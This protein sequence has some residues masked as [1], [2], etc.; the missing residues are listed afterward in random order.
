MSEKTTAEEIQAKL[1]QTFD[2]IE[3]KFAALEERSKDALD[4]S[5][6]QKNELEKL[7]QETKELGARLLDL[8]SAGGPDSGKPE[9]KSIGHEFANS[10][11]LRTL[12]EGGTKSIGMEFKNTLTNATRNGAQ[13]LVSPDHI[14]D[15]Q[16]Q[17]NRRLFLFDLMLK[18]A[19]SSNV[20]SWPRETVVNRAGPQVDGSP[21]AY[22]EGAVKP[23]SDYTFER[24]DRPVETIAH[25][26]KVSKQMLSDAEFIQSYLENRLMYHLKIE[27][28][29]QIV[30]GTGTKGEIYGLNTESTA[31]TLS[32]PEEALLLDRIRK[33]KTQATVA[34]YMPTTIIMNP[35]DV[36]TL[37]LTKIAGSDNRYLWGDPTENDNRTVW[38]LDVF[39]TNAQTAGTYTVLDLMAAMLF[40]AEGMTVGAYFEDSDNVQRNLVTLLAENRIVQA[41]WRTEA[42]RVGAT[43]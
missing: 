21:E 26:M 1:D 17:P 33:A 5:T 23:E 22:T 42:I 24:V 36:E 43:P 28:E 4:L 7:V 14:L 35:E 9:S 15:P 29:R 37:A 39:E 40:E 30:A 18:G 31:V 11:Q 34:E 12:R 32:S 8:E 13:P 3:T 2:K 10:D 19:T 38:G 25:H 6:E 27:N 41:V 16:H 20:V